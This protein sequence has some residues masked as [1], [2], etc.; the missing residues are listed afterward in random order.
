MP[1]YAMRSTRSLAPGDIQFRM[2]VTAA[3]VAHL[4]GPRLIQEGDKE[5]PASPVPGDWASA[6][7]HLPS[8]RFNILPD[9][10]HS[11]TELPLPAASPTE[12]HPSP[13]SLSCSPSLG[14]LILSLPF[15][16]CSSRL[17]GPPECSCRSCRLPIL[18]LL[19]AASCAISSPK[20]QQQHSI[21]LSG[22]ARSSGISAAVVAQVSFPLM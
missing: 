5:S 14:H 16:R 7:K 8:S 6:Q 18:T 1:L 21:L 15:Y 20:Q 22:A 3:P 12:Q 9:P 2:P 19:A 11:P 4:P 13:A 10:R 17:P